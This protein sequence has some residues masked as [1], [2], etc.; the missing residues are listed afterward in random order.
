MADSER[1]V[2]TL[3]GRTRKAKAMG[4]IRTG[5]ERENR[6]HFDDIV[7]NYD[8]VRWEYPTELYADIMNYSQTE[9]KTA[10]EIGAGTGKA[11]VPF[12]DSGYDV[13]AIEMGAN[14][15]A[16][17]KDKFKDNRL[18]ICRVKVVL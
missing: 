11:T 17:I 3:D 4:R 12:L 7:A 5:W 14:M 6:T 2:E 16:F 18:C 1:R 8:K 9:S 15:A 10:V 13:T